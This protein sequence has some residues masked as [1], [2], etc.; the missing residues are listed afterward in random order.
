VTAPG[1]TQDQHNTS[2]AEESALNAI[3]TEVGRSSIRRTLSISVCL[4]FSS[5][6]NSVYNINMNR[7]VKH[8]NYGIENW[9]E[10][11]AT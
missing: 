7:I 11:L 5:R 9:R 8:V 2:F 4:L 6:P 1:H 3:A 10:T